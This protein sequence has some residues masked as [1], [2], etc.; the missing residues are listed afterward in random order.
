MGSSS[1]SAIWLHK[2]RSLPQV[3]FKHEVVKHLTGKD[4]EPYDLITFS[5][6]RAS[7][8]C[9]R[10]QKRVLRRAVDPTTWSRSRKSSVM[11]SSASKRRRSTNRYPPP[12]FQVLPAPLSMQLA[13]F[14]Q[15]AS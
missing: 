10:I 1:E 12:Q 15:P 13:L 11:L 3:E 4:T 2:A 5:S 6:T 14:Q 9:S 7:C 8:R